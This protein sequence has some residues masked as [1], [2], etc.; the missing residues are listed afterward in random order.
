MK[1][2]MCSIFDSALQAYGRPVVMQ[3]VGQAMRSFADEVNSG[4]EDTDLVRH[5]QDFELWYLAEFEDGE[6]V[7]IGEPKL[8]AR[9]VDVKLHKKED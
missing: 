8:L 3:S 6:G 1:L 4:K 2:V 7:F 5:P 9:G